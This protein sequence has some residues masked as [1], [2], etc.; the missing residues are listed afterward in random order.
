MHRRAAPDSQEMIARPADEKILDARPGKVDLKDPH[1]LLCSTLE[2][3]GN[4]ILL[5]LLLRPDTKVLDKSAQQHRTLLL[6]AEH[7]AVGAAHAPRS[8]PALAARDDGRGGED[9]EEGEESEGGEEGET[10]E[11][12]QCRQPT[13]L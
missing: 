3:V 1:P 9:C 11:R 6:H 13:M 7:A 10:S 12:K 2:V 8:F 4:H 5:Q